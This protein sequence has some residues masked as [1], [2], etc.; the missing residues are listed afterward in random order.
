MNWQRILVPLA[1]AALVA[2][3]YR[4]FGWS[5]VALVAGGIVMWMLLHF[6]R[7]TQVLKRAADQPI[8]YVGS[9]VMLNS[10]LRANLTL[11][12]VVGLAR[13]LGEQLSPKEQQPEVFRWTDNSGS[14]V[15]CEF[16]QGKL[17]RWQLERPPA[18]AQEPGQAPR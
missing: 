1:G 6:T 12:H 13:A 18:E 10:R 7:L 11:L 3:A 4:S 15:T 16:E 14:R 9:A 8:G 2:F 5:G 17:A